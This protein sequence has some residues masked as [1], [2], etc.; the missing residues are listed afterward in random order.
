MANNQK[1]EEYLTEVIKRISGGRNEEEELSADSIAIP[2]EK[3]L[4]GLEEVETAFQSMEDEEFLEMLIRVNEQVDEENHI[5]SDFEED[6]TGGMEETLRELV[7]DA[8]PEETLEKLAKNKKPEE[9]LEELTREIRSERQ[10]EF[11]DIPKE[12]E[13]SGKEESDYISEAQAEF[14]DFSKAQAELSGFSEEQAE[15][16]DILEEQTNFGSVSEE[17]L[18]NIDDLT[19][20]KQEEFGD[21]LEEL[22]GIDDI[23]GEQEGFGDS[24]QEQE[25]FG[26]VLEEQEESDDI[27]EEQEEFNSSLEAESKNQGDSELELE[28]EHFALEEET[29]A[30]SEESLPEMESDLEETEKIKPEITTDF[31]EKEGET[32]QKLET[33]RN[34]VDVEE[35]LEGSNIIDF[36]SDLSTESTSSKHSAADTASSDGDEL[37]VS[38]DSL[39]KE[40]QGGTSS[41][42]DDSESDM[43]SSKGIVRE[44][45]KIGLE[46]EEIEGVE[47]EEEAE[48]EGKKKKK[49]AKKA[50]PKKAKPKKEK[51]EKVR[52]K[53][54]PKE[55]KPFLEQVKA[56][57]FRVEIVEPLSEEEEKK[58]KQLKLQEKEAKKKADAEEKKKKAA[59]KKEAAKKKKEEAAA[60]K[61]AKPKKEKKPKPP[62][63]PVSPEEIVH[64]RPMFLVFLTS[65]AAAIV[66]S[67]ITLS[68]VFGYSHAVQVA[69]NHLENGYYEEAF[70]ALN[71]L[72]IKQSD[73]EFYEA[74]RILMRV[75]KQYRSYV[76][77]SSLNMPNEALNSLV[78]AVENYDRYVDNAVNYGVKDSFDAIL[79]N[80]ES[81][82]QT[83]QLDLGTVREWNA[84]ED[85][86]EYTKKIMTCTGSY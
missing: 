48:E 60:K 33:K 12:Q 49:K 86:N 61:A 46:D 29:E 52:K 80:V 34:D 55:K 41:D 72:E 9:G 23:L 69:R 22:E 83:Y 19:E 11:D 84:L 78:K 75:E 6:T 74:V 25:S 42:T 77:Y 63:A 65:I 64:I 4:R 70:Q 36:D 66:L 2:D 73:Q 56:L 13:E 5:F 3:D 20:K 1:A 8:E 31:E 37:M 18:G 39:V 7:R 28:E 43:A 51:P 47:E 62:K 16:N 38:L 44:Y 21:V 45:D 10:M 24:L 32:E 71:G 15:L 30:L 85:K 14:N 40:I 58:Q 82:L 59:E 57:F 50:K 67:T 79:S 27:L 81:A 54:T 53:K 76:N 68:D 26:N 17:E 35:R